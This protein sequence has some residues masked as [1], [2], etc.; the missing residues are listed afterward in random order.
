MTQTTDH[1]ASPPLVKLLSE[2]S[3][4]RS[5]GLATCLAGGA[6]AAGLG[7]GSL[8][9]L[10]IAL[11]ISSPYPDSGPDGALHIAASLWLLA[12]GTE[13]VR[14]DTL[15]GASVPV[16]VTPLLLSALPAWLG[17]RAARD[18]ADPEDLGH[19]VGTAWCGVVSGYLLVGIAA[20][21]YA[22]G[23]ELRPDL[24][25]A[26]L[27]LP[28]FAAGAAACGVWAAL[29]R[30]RGPLPAPL[31]P[32]LAVL[33][34]VLRTRLVRGL[35][36]RGGTLAVARAGAAGAV[37]LVGGGALLVAVALLLRAGPVTE[38]FAQVTEVRS[39]QFAVLLLALALV[40]NA[41]VW[42]AA[43]GLGPGFAV[44][45][46][47]VATPLAVD[48]GPRLPRIPLLE[49][50]PEAGP[51]TPFDWA[52]GVV[53]VVAGLVV[54][55]CTVQSAAPDFGER[56]E[57][58]SLG[59]TAAGAAGA[60]VVCAVATAGLA[61]SAGGPMGVAVLAEFGPVWWRTGAAALCWTLP[62]AVP[63]AVILRAWRL[64]KR[65]GAGRGAGERSGTGGG[66]GTGTSGGA[67]RGRR[68]GKGTG[69]GTGSV[70]AAARSDA[71][72][73]SGAGR[74]AWTPRF[75]LPSPRGARLPRPRLPRWG[76]PGLGLPRLG[77]PRAV[78]A[79]RG[80]ASAE[81]TTHTPA[82][83]SG[84]AP[85]LPAGTTTDRHGSERYP[86][87]PTAEEA[88]GEARRRALRKTGE[89]P[90]EP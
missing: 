7:L 19:P 13:L 59:R 24:L 60:A 63:T 81:V 20:T 38:A 42:G 8:A 67:G 55:W 29:G 31:R 61:A 76:R 77:L 22:S 17:Y 15:S 39:G 27:H 65:S 73:A 79:R 28:V 51:G 57:A 21:V 10:V 23:G 35:F 30:P 88:S 43:Y 85:A 89:R 78:L 49:A 80:G 45:A 75:T 14:A 86:F 9:V 84:P 3:R 44:G 5:P 58:W 54:A 11:W 69:N 25:D 37:A 62:I 18:A 46:G 82:A 50:L 71:E 83:A 87:L 41:A 70:N 52:V 26:L 72:G 1:S 6:V 47:S 40:P 48:A 16:G 64:R 32:P 56:D 74:R 68:A 33:P 90:P 34:R 66:G 36:V 53:P 4:V 12:H 2:Q